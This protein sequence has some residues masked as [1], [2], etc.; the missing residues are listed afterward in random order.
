MTSRPAVPTE[1]TSLS[2][3]TALTALVALESVGSP[4]APFFIVYAIAALVIPIATGGFAFGPLRDAF[5]GHLAL[6]AGVFVVSFV[7]DVLFVGPLWDA[8]ATAAGH[9][10]SAY[11]SMTAAIDALLTTASSAYGFSKDTAQLIFAAYFL[12]WAPIAEELFY[13]GY[14]F[15][16]LR[17]RRSFLTAAVVSS[18]FFGLRHAT[19]FL[20]LMPNYPLIAAMV[21]AFDAFIIGIAYAALYE[22]T[23][24]LWPGFLVHLSI[25][26]IGMVLSG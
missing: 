24:S 3:A 20:Y 4:T 9:P 5:R 12:L 11:W 8:V 19:H 15:G 17:A 16:S 10:G 26:L 23:K 22:R 2:V 21:W 6:V 25:N 14:L 7:S 13:R 1:F 18:A